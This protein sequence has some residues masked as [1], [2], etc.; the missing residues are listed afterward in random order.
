MT[1][2]EKV[3]HLRRMLKATFKV[4]YVSLGITQGERGTVTFNLHGAFRSHAGKSVVIS[5]PA[6]TFGD[7]LSVLIHSLQTIDEK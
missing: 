3:D 5:K 6:E 2:G 7:M 1:T 4:Y